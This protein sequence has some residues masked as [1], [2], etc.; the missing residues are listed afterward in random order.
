MVQ[1]YPGPSVPSVRLVI[2]ASALLCVG[3][4]CPLAAS[5]QTTVLTFSATGRGMSV[6]STYTTQGYTFG[7]F[8]TNRPGPVD[9]FI[10]GP[11]NSQ[12]AGVP[13]LFNNDIYG[14][15]TLS[16]ANGAPFNLFSITMSP[17]FG[18]R[19]V[20]D[21]VFQG[22]LA[23]G[24]MVTQTF[25]LGTSPTSLSTFT[26]TDF[27]NLSSVQFRLGGFGPQR[28][29]DVVQFTNVE[30]SSTTTTPE[31]S[32]LALLGTGLVGISG[33]TMRRRRVK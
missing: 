7:G 10:T 3:A 21:V 2:L 32:S 11:T 20:N 29:P 1:Q 27:T 22:F 13:T 31:P 4:L 28:E 23:S 26:F 14:V 9:L 5:A 25:T 18:N 12:Y 16:Q 6:G 19:G 17:L 30:V 24:G 33:V 15:T 8:S